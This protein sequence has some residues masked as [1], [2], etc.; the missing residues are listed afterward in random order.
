MI[1]GFVSATRSRSVVVASARTGRHAR[2]AS[3]TVAHQSAVATAGC[4]PSG[5][6]EKPVSGLSAPTTTCATNNVPD[7]YIEKIG[8][9][10]LAANWHTYQILTKRAGRMAALL[11]GKLSDAAKAAL[12]SRHFPLV[13]SDWIMPGCDGLDLCRL[14]RS[15]GHAKYTYIV[16]LTS[17]GGRENFLAAMDAGV[18]DFIAKPLDREQ[19][20]ARLRVAERILGLP[21][22]PAKRGRR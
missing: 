14:V 2:T 3:A 6:G 17:V 9:V 11:Q 5:H 22:E 18:D 13:I 20:A 19:L 16:L 7:E 10:M 1:A 8:R 12:Q 4:A 15:G 21:K